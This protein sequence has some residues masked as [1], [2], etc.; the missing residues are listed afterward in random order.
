MRPWPLNESEAVKKG[1]LFFRRRFFSCSRRIKVRNF[2]LRIKGLLGFPLMGFFF[3][4][5]VK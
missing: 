4:I 2:V 5:F 1:K 3:S